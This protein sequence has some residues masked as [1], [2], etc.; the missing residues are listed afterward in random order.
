M[1]R[2]TERR[3]A[4]PVEFTLALQ[5]GEWSKARRAGRVRVDEPV[6]AAGS[7]SSRSVCPVGAVSKIT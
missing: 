4:G 1:R 2:V 7:L 5:A 6:H 3:Q